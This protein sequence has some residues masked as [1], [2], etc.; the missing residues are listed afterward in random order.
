MPIE[1]CQNA[2]EIHFILTFWV[3]KYGNLGGHENCL[4][5]MLLSIYI[6]IYIYMYVYKAPCLPV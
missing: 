6:Y 2:F 1:M 3:G 4:P 5:K